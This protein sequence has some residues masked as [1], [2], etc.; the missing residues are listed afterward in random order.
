MSLH[1]P[2]IAKVDPA[3]RQPFPSFTAIFADVNLRQSGGIKATGI[4]GVLRDFTKDFALKSG[5]YN[6]QALRATIPATANQFVGGK[7]KH[8]QSFHN[9]PPYGRFGERNIPRRP[10]GDRFFETKR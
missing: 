4:G 6:F 1:R 10:N 7:K 3:C 8:L 9:H 2:D 5:V